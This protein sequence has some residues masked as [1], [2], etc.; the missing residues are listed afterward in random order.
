MST[1]RTSIDCLISFET[2]LLQIYEVENNHLGKYACEKTIQQLNKVLSTLEH[3]KTVEM[4]GKD[5][6]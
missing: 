5:I 1:V 3:Y 4:T 6:E 2:S